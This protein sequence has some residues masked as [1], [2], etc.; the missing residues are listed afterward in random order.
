[1]RWI[2]EVGIAFKIVSILYTSGRLET[3]PGLENL[4]ECRLHNVYAK[5]NFQSKSSPK[6]STLPAE[7]NRNSVSP[8]VP[9]SVPELESLNGDQTGQCLN[10]LLRGASRVSISEHACVI[11]V[12]NEA[13]QG[14]INLRVPCKQ[15]LTAPG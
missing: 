10:P 1:M 14:K 12:Q 9:V 15:M 8:A 4:W 6:H 2:F 5:W 7:G 3:A 11:P 13:R